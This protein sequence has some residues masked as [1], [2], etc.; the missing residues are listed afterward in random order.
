MVATLVRLRFL[1]LFNTIKSSPWQI[2]ATIAGGLYGLGILMVVV[3]ALI[4][5][6]FAPPELARTAIVLGGAALI[7][8][9]TILPALTAG[10]DQTVDPA[11]L[12]AFP[13]PLDTLLVSLTVSGVLGV[14]GIVTSIAALAAAATWWQYPLAALVAVVCSAIGV[15]T[16]VVGSRMLIALGSR[17]NAGRRS[18][19]ARSA[20]LIVALLLIAPIVMFG[21]QFIRQLSADLPRIADIVA[22]TPVGA[23]WA[24][25]ADVA[26]G[27]FGRAGIEFLIG[28]ATFGV[29]LAL[30]RF[31]LAR[32]LETPE[33]S[34]SISTSTRG[35]G[36]FGVFPG[37]ATGAVAARALTYWVRD[38]RYAQS[39]IS[40]P[41][42]PIVIL[43]IAGA[44]ENLAPLNIVGPVVAL[45]LALSIYTDVSYDNT[46]YALH[47]QTGVSGRADRLGRVIALATFA[48]PVCLVATVATV[49]VV[50]T[51]YLLPALL[52]VTGGVLL[53]GFAISSVISGA[54]I[55]GVPAP[56]ESPFK[57]KPGGGFSLM[58]SMLVTWTALIILVLPS[59]ALA[60]MTWATGNM[61]YGWAGLLVGLGLGSVLLV[62]AVRVGGNVLDRRGPELLVQLQ[63]QK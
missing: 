5:L 9:W 61:A 11:R 31:G 42:I 19:E 53:T 51:W 23:I 7:L 50:D 2:V 28:L 3:T 41:V 34:S 32:A 13:I 22:F 14:P 56:G 52:G 38:P 16:A 25:P 8:G 57:S 15:L 60:L 4:G 20:A 30:W 37:S 47:L 46:A 24:V 17:L 35:L 12:V 29:F 63:Q 43:F 10:I 18:R 26:T 54:V 6:S 45:L 59:L 40:I 58:V 21:G 44:G 62:I 39:L 33:R 55:F 36:L 48:V 49:W 1:L 27:D